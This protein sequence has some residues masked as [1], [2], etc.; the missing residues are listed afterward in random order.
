[1]IDEVGELTEPLRD[2]R[3]LFSIGYITG[4]AFD[5][6]HARDIRRQMTDTCQTP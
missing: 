3:L 4:F 2:K 1:M 6:D 5:V